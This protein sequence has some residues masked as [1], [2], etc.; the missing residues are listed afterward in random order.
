MREAVGEQR[1]ARHLRQQVGDADARQHCVEAGGE[2]LGLQRCRFFDRRDLQ[3]PLLERDIG[4]QTALRL[5]VDRRQTRIEKGAAAGD[6]TLEIGIDCDRQGAG[7]Q[8][9]LLDLAGDQMLFEGAVAAAADDPDIA[10]AQPALQLRQH[11]EL[12]IAPVDRAA[13]HD[14]PGPSLADEASRGGFRQLECPSL[15]HVAQR[16]DRAQQRGGG[17]H[18]LEGEGREKSRSPAAHPTVML[19]QP[20]VGIEVLRARQRF[21]FGDAHA[22]ALLLAAA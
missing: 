16:V 18:A 22:K 3:H 17:R 8:Q 12:V 10:R 5:G 4:Q 19:T 15:V 2:C 11:T 21:R 14:V 9:L 13:G 6:E 20:L 1:P 7:L